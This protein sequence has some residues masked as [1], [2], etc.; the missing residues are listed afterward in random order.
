LR[1]TGTGSIWDIGEYE[2][3]SSTAGINLIPFQSKGYAAYLLNVI[4]FVPFGFLLPRIWTRFRNI[5][6]VIG[7]GAGFSLAIELCQLSNHRSTDIDDL[8]MNTLG[9]FIG[10]CIWLG[11]SKWFN[12][13]KPGQYEKLSEYEAEIYVILAVLG[14]FFLFNWRLLI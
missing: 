1:A 11:F 5:G 7:M 10:Y 13:K 14:D 6:N 2:S 3:I 8:S 4:L 9:A 12:S